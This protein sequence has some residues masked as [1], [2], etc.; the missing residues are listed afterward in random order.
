LITLVMSA[1]ASMISGMLSGL[2]LIDIGA[3]FNV[4]V[5]IA[6]QMLTFSFIVSVVFALLTSVLTLKYNHKLLLQL[7]L[8]TY[9]LSAI[10]CF[11]APNFTA[12]IASY[13]LTGIGYALTTT[14]V[15]TLAAELFPVERRGGV[16]GWIVAGMSGSYL[17]GAFVVPF[18]QNIAGW[19]GTFIG[20]L[21]PFSGLALVLA[22]TSIPGKVQGQQTGSQNGLKESFKKVFSNRSAISSLAGLLFAMAAW[23]S[24]M[25]YFSSFFREG[26]NW[27]IG[28]TSILVLFGSTLYTVGSIACGRMMNRMGRKPLTVVPILIAGIGIISFSRLPIAML[29]GGV[30]CLICLMVGVMDAASTSLIIEQLPAY[31]GVMMSLS[32]AGTQLGFSVGSGLGGVSLLLYGYQGM[33][34]LLGS[35]AIV[36][37]IM[38]H[39]FTV[40]PLKSSIRV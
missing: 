1:L 36:S 38:F 7:G 6:G 40:D 39:F 18:I 25:A 13:S 27:T 14:M 11:L 8:A 19:R 15:F 21:L 35:F 2:Q 3:T 26:F 22:T 29:A 17:I 16:I 12:M 24:V 34:L 10:G 31:T 33:F 4:T 20:Y 32:R 30:I 28:D 23:Q 37:A 9:A 5:A